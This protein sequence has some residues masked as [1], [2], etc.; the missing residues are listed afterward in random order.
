LRGA[1]T[2]PGIGLGRTATLADLDLLATRLPAFAALQ[3]ADRQRLV[4]EMRYLQAEPGTVIVRQNE[5]SDAAYF[6]LEGRT[7]AGRQEDGSERILETHSPGDF[8]GEIAA[9]TGVPRTA[10]VVVEEAATLL[11][12]PAATL[13][14]MAADANLNRAFMSKMT[15]RMVRMNMLDIPRMVGPDQDLMRDLRTRE[16]QPATA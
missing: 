11:K 9:L 10:N 7:V 15:E 13:R 8:F 2:A 12:V 16:P 6:L 5:Q 4:A 3:T 1:A 14:K